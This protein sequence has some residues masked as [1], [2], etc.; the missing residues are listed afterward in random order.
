LTNQIGL[1]AKL[2]D[3]SYVKGAFVPDP[4]TELEL[5]VA[6]RMDVG[7][8]DRPQV[9]DASQLVEQGQGVGSSGVALGAEVN[10][11][12]GA[13]IEGAKRAYYCRKNCK[14]L[15]VV[16]EQIQP[17]IAENLSNAVL[18][19]FPELLEEAKFVVD[20]C[21]D[22]GVR[23][24]VIM[25][26][27]S[28]Y[29]M[30]CWILAVA[31]RIA[32]RCRSNFSLDDEQ[33]KR[34]QRALRELGKL[35]L[36]AA[37]QQEMAKLGGLIP[38][39]VDKED[40]AALRDA[41]HRYMM[42]NGASHLPSSDLRFAQVRS[43]PKMFYGVEDAPE[44]AEDTAWGLFCLS[45]FNSDDPEAIPD[46]LEE[47]A[48]E[49]C[50]ACAGAPLTLKVVSGAMAGKV[51]V[52]EW[53]STLRHLKNPSLNPLR[54]SFD[55]LDD[56][57]KKC[58]L[59]FAAFSD[60]EDQNFA[61]HLTP[62]SVRFD[63]MFLLW[64][65]RGVFGVE[66]DDA[67]DEAWLQW[68]ILAARSLIEMRP[69]ESAVLHP[70]VRE[71]AISITQSGCAA[72]ECEQ[73]F[74]LEPN[75]HL[76]EFP[77]RWIEQTLKAELISLVDNELQTLPDRLHAPNL[78]TLLLR[79]NA[80]L[81]K[82]PDGFLRS[83]SSSLQVLDLSRTFVE[84]L[85]DDIGDLA[86]LVYLLL[87]ECRN[88]G[89]LPKSIGS[90]HSLKY[91]VLTGAYAIDELPEEISDL[92]HLKYL[93]LRGC[94]GLSGTLPASIGNLQHLEYLDLYHCGNLESVPGEVRN[95]ASLKVLKLPYDVVWKE[96]QAQYKARYYATRDES[97]EDFEP[98][99]GAAGLEDIAC[100]G[101]LKTL[102]I[103][104][105]TDTSS[106]DSPIT[107]LPD[108]ELERLSSSILGIQGLEWVELRHFF[109]ADETKSLPELRGL[110]LDQ[111]RGM[112]APR[113]L[114][115]CRHLTY[116]SLH[117]CASL[118]ELPAL[119]SL[120]D[121]EGLY[122][123]ECDELTSIP[124]SFT[125]RNA[126]VSLVRFS[127]LR[128]RQLKCEFPELES[129]DAMPKLQTLSLDDNIRVSNRSQG[130]LAQR[131]LTMKHQNQW[132]HLNLLDL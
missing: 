104:E 90:L 21:E 24:P 6:V 14:Q 126:F 49:V 112:M 1:L 115:G 98:D 22:G 17:L 116:L 56:V 7:N 52:E 45:A 13:V 5:V 27:W 106:R 29:M 118:K 36:A 20:A 73:E 79:E 62:K 3:A 108:A 111:A 72:Q 2:W 117:S 124:S 94:S 74:L 89:A 66:E 50:K 58:F 110:A 70:L 97:D 100:L 101:N 33:W 12:L 32:L 123:Y 83:L 11:L 44:V 25:R 121:L 64:H 10:E 67:R 85:P 43:T 88:L 68:G 78:R 99:D 39:A 92:H 95:L 103:P 102:Q 107:L 128:C 113:W 93:A 71:F 119:D 122:V 30:S 42:S 19:G 76:T 130:I 35:T 82:I 18:F 51:D 60:Q 55:G 61:I 87:A 40:T 65:S 75:K 91:L 15:K 81:T 38:G 8:D 120:P 127:C 114:E 63:D 37:G 48:R 23:H 77:R 109:V 59:Y 105:W 131:K 9:G 96:A 69:F 16:L 47:V 26:I 80:T 41:Y 28:K 53:R 54:I 46:E 86:Q 129:A 57:T 34:I 4:S 132:Q 125:R 84:R 31:Q